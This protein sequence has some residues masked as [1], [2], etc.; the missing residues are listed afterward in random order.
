MK[1]TIT[2]KILLILLLPFLAAA[3]TFLVFSLTLARQ[4]ED[5]VPFTDIAGRQRMLS[6]ALHKY[7]W[8]VHIG[9]EEDRPEL[10]ALIHRFEASLGAL[11]R[12]GRPPESPYA[13]PPPPEA[14]VPA[15]D[16]VAGLWSRLKPELTRVAE[17]PGDDP[18][19]LQAWGMVDAGMPR[20]TAA[21][22]AVVKAYAAHDTE[23]H[24]QMGILLGL[25]AVFALLLC[26]AGSWAA[27][28]FIVRPVHLLMDRAEAVR[29]GDY[30]HRVEVGTRDELAE[31]AASF[32]A[33]AA[34]LH[35]REEHLRF[36]AM[37]DT[38]TGL[39]NRRLLHRHLAQRIT[40]RAGTALI[41]IGLNRFKAINETLGFTAGDKVLRKVVG[42][43]KRVEGKDA[44]LA[45][46]SGDVFALLAPFKAEEEALHIARNCL[47]A[48]EPTL[49]LEDFTLDMQASTG[50][51]LYPQHGAGSADDL[52]R[53][54]EVA[55]EAAKRVH[56]DLAVYDTELEEYRLEHL[57]LLGEL[58]SAIEKDELTLYYQP[59]VD[60][61]TRRIAGV[62]ALVR[63]VHPKRGFLPPDVFMP[64]AEESGIMHALTAW[65]LRQGLAQLGRW[66]AAAL[67]AGFRMG[68][69]VAAADLENAAFTDMVRAMVRAA[70]IEPACLMLEITESGLMHD[71]ERAHAA[72]HRLH[73]IGVQLS[74]DD[75]GTG[76]S[77]LAYLKDMPVQEIKIDRSFVRHMLAEEKSAAIVHA[78]VALAHN[79]GL[80]VVA[81]GVEDEAMW[82]H[83]AHLG[84]DMAQGY[85][86]GRPMPAAEFERWLAES[87]WGAR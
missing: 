40:D 33:M 32:N 27:R 50:I 67:P 36:L 68:V 87:P 78:T 5:E 7:A 44:L 28:R 54:A 1:A 38:L 37:H 22:N 63:W 18:R 43:L 85:Y 58:R 55:M 24:R 11:R 15:L 69:N 77:S 13:L 86:M 80:K 84:C 26:L 75:F 19:S 57:N 39:P 23:L 79:M 42:R 72:L 17:L 30:R 29:R 25:N 71:P 46:I 62:E 21:A 81:E 34:E 65:V 52:L 53:Q 74:I 4:A 45:R 47:T 83:L 82:N 56:T 64:L 61:K 12:G 3:T 16:E 59:K 31:L 2:R 60:M 14:V 48:L 73:D 35:S 8:M 20:L 6:E 9:Q 49:Q 66:Q 70:N 41:F 51:A 10:V 76:Y